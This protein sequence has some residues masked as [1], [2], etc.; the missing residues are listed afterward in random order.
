MSANG[1]DVF[2]RTLH[3]TNGWLKEISEDLEIDRHA[4]WKVLSVVLHKL[5]DRLPVDLSAHLGSQL[6]LLVRGVYY[7]QYQPAKQPSR[8]NSAEEFVE[9]VGEW[10]TDATPLEPR[11]AAEAV[12]GVLSRHLAAGQVEKVRTNLPKGVRALWS[13]EPPP[14]RHPAAVEDA[15][16]QATGI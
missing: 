9:E 8:C 4:A 3:T 11:R 16:A 12:F 5:R 6:P 10:L 14:R 1:L 2:D 7:D 13:A 15:A